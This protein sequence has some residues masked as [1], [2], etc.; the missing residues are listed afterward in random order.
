MKEDVVDLALSDRL[1][2]GGCFYDVKNNYEFPTTD[3]DIIR[4]GEWEP[5]RKEVRLATVVADESGEEVV[6]DVAT[7]WTT[8][9]HEI[10]HAIMPITSY[11]PVKGS[12]PGED[13]DETE[14]R[15]VDSL[16]EALFMVLR[17]N[18]ELCSSI[19]QISKALEL[20]DEIRNTKN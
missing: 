16:A 15:I 6:L 8:Y 2:V 1:K 5:T 20:E 10:L 18:P 14:N 7:R 19:G 9:I 17:D 11:A 12:F 13:V 3:D 4:L